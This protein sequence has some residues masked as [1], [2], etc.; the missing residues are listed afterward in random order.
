M[1]V[2]PAPGSMVPPLDGAPPALVV[3]PLKI[4]PPLPEAPP[5]LDAPP[6]AIEPPP[7]PV[8]APLPESEPLSEPESAP[9]PLWSSVEPT[10]GT[11]P[12]GAP[13]WPP[14]P[15][16]SGGG[17]SCPGSKLQAVVPVAQTIPT[18]NSAIRTRI[19][20]PPLLSDDVLAHGP[21]VTHDSNVHVMRPL[22]LERIGEF[23][24]VMTAKRKH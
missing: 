20:D 15:K 1:V 12:A 7:L 23:E 10:T 16:L 11:P 13:P 14:P 3:P 18:L 24:Y 21:G 19:S 9:L 8:P 4:A 2:P 22:A 5:A 6:V 17:R